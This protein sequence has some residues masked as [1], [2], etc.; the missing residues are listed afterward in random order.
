MKITTSKVLAI[1]LLITFIAAGIF[2]KQLY[3]MK[4]ELKKHMEQTSQRLEEKQKSIGLQKKKTLESAALQEGSI[5]EL[6]KDI[7]LLKEK[8]KGEVKKSQTI[9]QILEDEKKQYN[10]EM[11]RLTSIISNLET[12]LD[13]IRGTHSKDLDRKSVV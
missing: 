11:N 1:L 7:F 9:R 10:Q 12:Q 5:K 3:D 6:K 2:Y 4:N 13:Q 8:F